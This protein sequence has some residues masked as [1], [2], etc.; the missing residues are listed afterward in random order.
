[1][2]THP[3]LSLR[4]VPAQKHITIKLKNAVKIPNK[5][6][7]PSVVFCSACN[8]LSTI[9]SLFIITVNLQWSGL[10]DQLNMNLGD[11][12]GSV[13]LMPGAQLNS[14]VYFLPLSRSE[15]RAEGQIAVSADQ[16]FISCRYRS[17]PS[18]VKPLS[19]SA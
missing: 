13:P 6:I 14:T 16:P 3:L 12:K 2:S 19:R 18:F 15:R 9:L 11:G 4:T 10:E 8:L 1:M 7:N 17:S 5:Q